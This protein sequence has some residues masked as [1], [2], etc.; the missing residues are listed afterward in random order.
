MGKLTILPLEHFVLI[1]S[2]LHEQSFIHLKP[3]TGSRAQIGNG[4]VITL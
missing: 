2:G 1:S 3:H 4:E